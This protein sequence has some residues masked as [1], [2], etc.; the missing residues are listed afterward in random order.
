MIDTPPRCVGSTVLASLPGRVA[1]IV[2]YCSSRCDKDSIQFTHVQ[3]LYR[4]WYVGIPT[5]YMYV[6]SHLCDREELLETAQTAVRYVHG[7]CSFPYWLSEVCVCVGGGGGGGVGNFG[8]S[9]L[10]L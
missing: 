4:I 3:S 10:P 8:I 7:S 9:E 5:L 6:L 1:G 2:Q